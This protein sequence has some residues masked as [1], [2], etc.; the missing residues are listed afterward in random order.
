MRF[1][2]KGMLRE[3]EVHPEGPARA[4]FRRLTTPVGDDN[5]LHPSFAR[6]L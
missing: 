1:V 2:P 6:W 5:P 3:C 4:S